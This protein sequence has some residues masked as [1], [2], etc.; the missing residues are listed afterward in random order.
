MHLVFTRPRLARDECA[1]ARPATL[2][3]ELVGVLTTVG[4]QYTDLNHV[5]QGPVF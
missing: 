1:E 3:A 2:V 4:L 5:H